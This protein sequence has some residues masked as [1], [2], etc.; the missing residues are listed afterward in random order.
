MHSEVIYLLCIQL[1]FLH[2]IWLLF[3]VIFFSLSLNGPGS[4]A[5]YPG[6]LKDAAVAHNSMRLWNTT[7][8]SSKYLQFNA[9]NDLFA[10]LLVYYDTMYLEINK[11]IT[12]SRIVE[13]LFEIF[14]L[15][16]K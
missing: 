10:F 15:S 1:H 3:T 14:Q 11:N 13:S 5:T 16:K 8:N 4:N 12:F 7:S 2:V 6:K 9:F